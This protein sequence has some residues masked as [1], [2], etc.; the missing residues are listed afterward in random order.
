MTESQ[1]QA[2]AAIREK[3]GTRLQFGDKNGPMHEPPYSETEVRV[4]LD[5]IDGLTR[6]RDEAK[7]TGEFGKIVFDLIMTHCPPD[8]LP[9]E[10]DSDFVINGWLR[11]RAARDEALADV[12][13]L[14]A[15]LA[16]ANARADG[17]RATVVAW[18]AR[19][20]DRMETESLPNLRG[21]AYLDATATINTLRC[22]AD[23]IERGEHNQDAAP[24]QE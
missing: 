24:R 6:E 1:Q 15:E 11:M 9:R 5:I 14:T 12:A 13:R 20:A 4:L 16:A 21:H 22:I 8:D 17:E 10:A 7:P 19:D 2:L 3:I 18:L 23:A